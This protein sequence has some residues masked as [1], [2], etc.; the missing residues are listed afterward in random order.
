MNEPSDWLC[1]YH[2]VQALKVKCL[3]NTCLL[4]SGT[5]VASS[6]DLAFVSYKHV[7]HYLDLNLTSSCSI[8]KLA[9][10]CKSFVQDGVIYDFQVL[11][12][13]RFNQ[14]T[15]NDSSMPLSFLYTGADT[16]CVRRHILLPFARQPEDEEVQ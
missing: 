14:L 12:C 5:Q 7:S 8:E 10:N 13:C 11:Q 9:C 2:Q 16:A 1:L 4:I 3:L 15:N 6:N